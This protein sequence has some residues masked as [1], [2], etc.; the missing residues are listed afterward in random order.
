[1]Y[2]PF[3]TVAKVATTFKSNLPFS[4]V[5]NAKM[6]CCKALKVNKE[7]KF[8]KMRDNVNENTIKLELHNRG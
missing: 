7:S 4:T 6:F 5:S 8:E 3:L 1:M 2:L